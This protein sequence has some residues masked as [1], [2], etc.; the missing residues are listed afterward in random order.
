MRQRW[1]Q[2]EIVIRKATSPKSLRIT[3]PDGRSSVEVN[4]YPKGDTKSSATVK[5]TKLEHGADVAAKKAYW[6]ESLS[7]L[8]AMLEA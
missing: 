2:E 8:K 7:R 4:L 5:H 3:W 6:S 1:L